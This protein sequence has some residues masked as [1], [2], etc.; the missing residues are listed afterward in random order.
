M[1]GVGTVRLLCQPGCG[2]CARVR[3][4]LDGLGLEVDFVDVTVDEAARSE[5]ERRGIFS[6]PVVMTSDGNA[7]WGWSPPD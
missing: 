6:L 3:R 4:W 7:G 5:L 2:K 1:T